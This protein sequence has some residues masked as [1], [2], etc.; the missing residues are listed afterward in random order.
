MDIDVLVHVYVPVPVHVLLPVT[1]CV[2]LRVTVRVPLRVFFRVPVHFAIYTCVRYGNYCILP[3]HEMAR[4][5][6][7]ASHV[8][9][10]GSDQ[11]TVSA[12]LRLCETYG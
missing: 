6:K 8:T 3:I 9:E 11:S 4:K 12:P 5:I 7:R 2:P 10:D 1:V